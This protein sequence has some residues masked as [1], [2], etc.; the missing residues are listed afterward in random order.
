MKME[1]IAEVGIAVQNLEDTS[2]KYVEVLGAVPSEIVPLDQYGNRYRMC[3]I[4]DVDLKL[5][6]ATRDNDMA[7]LV[8]ERRGDWFYYVGFQVS[9]VR[10]A[11]AW[12]KRNGIQMIDEAP[13]MENGQR[14]AFTYPSSFRGVTFKLIEGKHSLKYLPEPAAQKAIPAGARITQ[15]YHVGVNVLDLEAATGLYTRVLG[16]RPSREVV[17]RMYDMRITMNRI[18]DKDFELLCP[19]SLEGTVGKSIAKIGEGIAQLAFSVP[20]LKAAIAWMKQSGIR[21]VDEVPRLTDAIQDWWLAF[22]HPK[23]FNGTMFELIEGKHSLYE[24]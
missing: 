1:R 24:E 20:D 14:F 19:L 3:R 7:R 13:R 4:G 23:G 15:L 11:I 21:M 5:M 16:T 17:I 10:E 18:G 8:E 12:M 22:T 9:S 6:Q 2:K